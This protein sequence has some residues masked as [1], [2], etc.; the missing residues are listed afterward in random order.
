VSDASARPLNFTVRPQQMPRRST[1]YLYTALLVAASCSLQDE[2]SRVAVPGTDLAVVLSQD[3]KHL[4]RCELFAGRKS[5]S[6]QLICGAPD[7]VEE[8]VTF[9][10]RQQGDSF[11]IHW[12]QGDHH[13]T[14]VRVDIRSR[15]VEQV[16]DR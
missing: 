5:I 4:W 11:Y 6:E 13:S 8:R 10:T 2:L 3:E 1:L 14:S 15:T 7:Y 12:T 16:R 9:T